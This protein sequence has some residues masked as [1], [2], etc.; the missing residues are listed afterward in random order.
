MT[1]QV[2]ADANVEGDGMT[3]QELR[4]ILKVLVSKVDDLGYVV[5]AMEE[6]GLSDEQRQAPA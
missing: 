1:G 2:F 6:K 4:R 5:G 3:E